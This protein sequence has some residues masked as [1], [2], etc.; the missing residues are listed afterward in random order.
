[1]LR[2]S[3]RLI[4]GSGVGVGVGDGVTVGVAVD[5][6]VTVIVAVGG[7]GVGVTNNPDTWQASKARDKRTVEISLF[8]LCV[9]IN[10]IQIQKIKGLNLE[11]DGLPS[12]LTGVSSLT[13]K[14]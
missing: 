11:S 13:P 9:F 12:K 2:I 6:G 5:D 1:M 8:A 7:I 3:T 4:T 14:S 10:Y